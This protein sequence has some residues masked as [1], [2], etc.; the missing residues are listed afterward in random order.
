MAAEPALRVRAF[1]KINLTLQVVGIR[2]DGY[3]ELS[4][5]FQSVD[6]HDTLTFRRARGPFALSCDDERCPSDPSNL[7]WRAADSAWQAAGRR[8]APHGI[9]V[10]LRKRI[11]IE[12]GL[13]G[14]S[15]DAAAALR[16][17][18]HLWRVNSRTL[19][20]I[21][22]ELGADVPFFFEGG[23]C[24]GR[25]RGDRL[26]P[27]PDA[28]AAWVVLVMPPFGVSTREAFGW[29]DSAVTRRSAAVPAGRVSNDLEAC[30][31]SRYPIVKELAGALSSLGAR[32][33]AMTGSGSTVFGLFDRRAAAEA[34]AARLA[35]PPLRAIVC[36]TLN[37]ARYAR[38]ARPE[39][40][41]TA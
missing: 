11:P 23:T 2:R 10:R 4:T 24:L 8:G 28:P 6:L 22:A 32:D 41:G 27:Q 39:L 3:H 21:G 34:A 12:A 40:Q 16:A 36:R 1:A 37:R 17:C 15:S 20:T 18:G 38:R 9:R 14:G 7:I 5:V 31:A 26:E 13:G 35:R 19:R 29:Y 33:A 30:V 25:G